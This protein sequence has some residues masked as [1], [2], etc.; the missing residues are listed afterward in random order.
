M[1]RYQASVACTVLPSIDPEDTTGD[2]RRSAIIGYTQNLSLDAIALILPSSQT[3][4]TD[5]SN[6][7]TAA[8]LVLALP[9]GYVE[10]SGALV[11]HQEAGPKDNLFVFRIE[12]ANE[13]DRRL[14]REH[15][16]SLRR[17]RSP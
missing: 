16:D 10:L 15:L 12:G 14:Y 7:G 4:G 13:M 3:Y 8:E 17:K 5:P 1:P 11:R 9:V 2:Q 6:L